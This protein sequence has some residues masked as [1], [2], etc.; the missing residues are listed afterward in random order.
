[1]WTCLSCFSPILFEAM[2]DGSFDWIKFSIWSMD[3]WAPMVP[4]GQQEG[5]AAGS[6]V[7]G[8]MLFSAET[9]DPMARGDFVD[10]THFQVIL[11]SRE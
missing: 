6:L 10:H 3:S 7:A 8:V 2:A 1:M 11:S 5:V 9:R 4:A